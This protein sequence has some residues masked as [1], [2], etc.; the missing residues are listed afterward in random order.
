MSGLWSTLTPLI[1]G[2]ALVP[3]QLII[4]IL[5]LRSS[6]GRRTA[7]AWVGG[8][9]AVRIV[10]GLVFGLLLSSGSDE[11]TSTGGGSPF[12]SGLL[13]VVALLLLAS[14][15]KQ[16][17]SDVDPDAPPPKWLTAAES[18]GPGKAFAFGAGLLTIGAKFWIF[19][20]GALA[21]I[22][23]ADLGRSQSIVAFVLF[24]VLAE[25]L[26]L[27]IV[28]VA[29]A[30]PKASHAALEKA[31]TWLAAK[32]RVIMIV[33]GFVFGTWF[34]VKGLDGLGVI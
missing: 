20:L 33:L 4:T 3:I 26:H 8:M 21:A 2:S 30:A 13:L 1:I 11:V 9:T 10:Q 29:F 19:T 25:S 22:G 34:L 5:L 23:D 32:N 12:V 17:V 27:A 6:A 31:S 24:I 16:L 15:V 7:V 28:G 14:A 18:M